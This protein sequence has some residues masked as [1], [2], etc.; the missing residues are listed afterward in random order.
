M[1]WIERY[2]VYDADGYYRSGWETQQQATAAAR[3]I[4]EATG[5][6]DV[7]QILIG[8]HGST[9]RTSRFHRGGRIEKLWREF[10]EVS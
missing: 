10:E 7:K 2:L 5:S 9:I 3:Q 4:A 6:A 8:D 1:I